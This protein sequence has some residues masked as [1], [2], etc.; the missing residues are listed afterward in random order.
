MDREGAVSGITVCASLCDTLTG[1]VDLISARIKSAV[2]LERTVMPP[3][4]RKSPIQLIRASIQERDEEA[5]RDAVQHI[6]PGTFL[7]ESW[8]ECLKIVLSPEFTGDPA[9]YLNG[10][11]RHGGDENDGHRRLL[12]NDEIAR[13]GRFEE[14][15][16]EYRDE[17]MGQI[18]KR[19]LEEIL[20][21]YPH[22][23]WTV[24]A[25]TGRTLFHKAAEAG[26]C[27]VIEIVGKFIRLRRGL[28]GIQTTVRIRDIVN[29]QTALVIAVRGNKASAVNA[30]KALMELDPDQLD[31]TNP[32]AQADIEFAVEGGKLHILKSLLQNRAHLVTP[33]LFLRA[34]SDAKYDILE[35]LVEMRPE[36]LRDPAANFLVAAVKRGQVKVVDLLVERFPELTSQYEIEQRK[37]RYILSFNN[38]RYFTAEQGAR[39]RIRDIVLPVIIERNPISRQV[40]LVLMDASTIKTSAKVH[41]LPILRKFCTS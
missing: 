41:L 32:M 19:I 16:E 24:A 25:D 39:A 14:T 4:L 20:N 30:V 9:F 22:L 26:A 28:E 13:L 6:K 1:R 35:Y 31:E 11:L 38:D 17:E 21:L 27:S 10:L 3:A 23:A 2:C 8:H 5:F 7:I 36:M 33:A 34:L 29:G 12:L 15:E 18:A 37:S 40:S